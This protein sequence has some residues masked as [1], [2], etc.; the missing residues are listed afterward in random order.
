MTVSTITATT[1]QPTNGPSH[2][3]APPAA[4]RVRMISSGA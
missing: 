1:A 3:V 2:R 4:T